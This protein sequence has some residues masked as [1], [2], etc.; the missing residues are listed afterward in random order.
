MPG[1]NF[2]YFLHVRPLGVRWPDG[3]SPIRKCNGS[4]EAKINDHLR[5]TGE[6]MN[7][8]GRMIVGMNDKENAFE[9]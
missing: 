9:L 5:L 4:V 8:P 7:M 6:T 2:Q 1:R 3:I